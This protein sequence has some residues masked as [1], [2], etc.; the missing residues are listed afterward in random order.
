M[1]DAC[2]PGFRFAHAGYL[3][4]EEAGLAIGHEVTAA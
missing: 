2:H 4:L 3:L 1:P